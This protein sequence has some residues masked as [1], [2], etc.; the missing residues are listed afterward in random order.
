MADVQL[1]C[2]DCASVMAE[3]IPDGAIDLTVTGAG[4]FTYNWAGM[5]SQQ[6]QIDDAVTRLTVFPRERQFLCDWPQARQ[7]RG[8]GCG[9]QRRPGFHLH[10]PQPGHLHPGQR[11][12]VP[13][14]QP[15]PPQT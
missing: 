3:Q 7:A 6:G 10:Q 15:R 1:Y 14:T 4:T 5:G 13:M 12:Q 2:G 8:C 9:I 11:A